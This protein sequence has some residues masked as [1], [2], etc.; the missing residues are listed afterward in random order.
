VPGEHNFEHL[1]LF[2]RFQGAARL[3]NPPF[4]SPQSRANRE[5]RVAHSAALRTVSESLSERWRENR[6]GRLNQDL[7]LL[8]AGIPLLL[9]IDPSL[10]LDVLRE[11]F[12]FE[13]VAEQDEGFVIVA[14]ED[15]DLTRFVAMVNAFSV[16]VHGSAT[17]AQVH[18]LFD[19]PD[20]GDR[21]SRIL[22]ESLFAIWPTIPD[23]TEYIVDVGIACTGIVEIPTKPKR[24]KRDSDASWARKERNWSQARSDAYNV[25]DELKSV[26]EDEIAGFV[27]AYGGEILHLIDGAAFEAAVLPDSFTVRIRIVGQGLKDFVLNYAYIFEVVEPEDIFLPQ[28]PL[29]GPDGAAGGAQPTAP[30]Q[31]APAVCVID[32]G[33]QEGHLLLQPAI[34][35]TESF[36]FVKGK[37]ETDVGDFVRPSGH[38]TRVAGVVLYGEEVA[39][40]GSPQL[41]FWI[42]N[43]RVLDENNRMPPNMFPPE[44]ISAAVRRYC[45]GPRHTRIFN[46]SINASSYCRTQYMSAWAAEIDLL[47]ADHDVLIVQSAGNVPINGL[48]SQLGI[49]DHLVGGRQYPAYLCEASA[50]IANPGQSLQALTVGS[51]AYGDFQADE[52][53]TFAAES[54][55]PSAFSR[56]GLSIWSTIKPEVVEYGGDDVRTNNVPPDIQGGGRI[57]TACPELVRSTLY[58]PGPAYD[59]DACG[60]S[61][62]APK[63]TRI[64]ARLA[65]L[66]PE[67]P[68]LLYRSLIVQSARWP[69]WAEAILTALRRNE[70]PDEREQLLDHT[71]KLIRYL[72]FGIPDEGRATANS[73]HRTTFITN[74]EASMGPAEC[75]IYQ[76]P[77]PAEIRGQ[78]DEFDIRIE[79][80]LSYVAQPRR[81]RR[82]VRRYLSTWLD[83]KSSRLGEGID[84][85]RVRAMKDES[86]EGIPLSGTTLPWTLQDQ[87]DKGLIRGVRRNSGTVQ[88]DWAIVNSNS[89]P[90][91]FC[92]AIV[93][94]R[95]W[96]RDPDS[97]ARYALAVTVEVVDQEIAIYEHLR[98]AMFELQSNL[99]TEIETEID[100]EIE[101]EAGEEI[102]EG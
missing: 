12:S 63:V 8:P 33:I 65:S 64:A 6:E 55:Y 38:G 101:T 39:K 100:I 47:C 43:A 73:D 85:F 98:T 59:R 36:C 30:S 99:E 26:R 5:A 27:V 32:S 28:N 76:I 72:G 44:V 93:G 71:S 81:T 95:G 97:A 13:I 4:Q 87:S 52:W 29:A 83:W 21:L 54:G 51:V 3:R 35:G 57:P 25:W 19:D 37:T 46:H 14:S 96:S 22:S 40:I 75:H 42:Q 89:L 17:V 88:K 82:N 45:D 24:G 20:Q 50:R 86:I 1:P 90:D 80:T 41:P 94:H 58:A 67:E 61:F 68:T 92:I 66:L 84:D 11:K 18:R 77:I 60:T 23:E 70:N 69:G 31:T 79:V 91:H 9:Q 78:A 102:E 74:G 2:L 34:D 48:A 10:D 62:A 49:A 7:P 56:A 15:L 16:A 53:K